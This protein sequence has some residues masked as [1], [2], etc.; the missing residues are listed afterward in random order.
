MSRVVPVVL[1]KVNAGCLGAPRS[2]PERV[3]ISYDPERPDRFEVLTPPGEVTDD[4]FEAQKTRLLAQ[5]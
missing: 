1:G 5:Q 4:E 3:T 2:R